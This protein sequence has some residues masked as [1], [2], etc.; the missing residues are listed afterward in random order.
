MKSK[1]LP[2]PIAIIGGGLA[3]LTAANYLQQKNVPFVLYEAGKKIA[4]L[5]TS[6]KD[7][8]GFSYD[9]GAHFVTNRLAAM[10][11]VSGEC[12]TIKHYSETVL[13]GG[14]TYAYPFGLMKIPRMT[15]S[16]VKSRLFKNGK[17]KTAQNWFRSRYGKALA[18]EVALPLIEA[19]SGAKA[20]QLSSSVGESLPGSIAKTIYL[21]IAGKVLKRAVCI[22][23]SREL[24]ESANVWHV[25]PNG[26]VHTLCEKLAEGIKDKIKLESPVEEIIVENEKVVAVRAKGKLQE[27]SAVISTAPVN[28]LAKLVKGTDKLNKLAKFRYRPMTFINMRFEGRGL[29]PDVVLWLPEDKYPFFRLTE[30]TLSMPWLAPEGKTIITVDIGCEKDDEFWKMENEKLAE[31]CLEHLTSIIPDAREKYL[32]CHVLRTPISYPVFLNEYEAE[33]QDFEKGTGI[34]NLLSVGRNG[35]F[36]H[37]FMEDVYWR[38]LQK[39][40]ELLNQ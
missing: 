10:I 20:D 25:Y 37:I 16:G 8:E 39:T 40:R 31:F 18:D 27:V 26:G 7:E 22:G 11:G 2:K 12:K 5:A 23:Y 38:T 32:G 14:K 30:A 15:L 13:L 29:L 36:S 6:F 24:P 21:K 4:G 33:R 35:E 34:E 19:W 1:N 17:E 3:G 28:I 9:F